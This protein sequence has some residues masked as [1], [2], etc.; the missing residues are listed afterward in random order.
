MNLTVSPP[1]TARGVARAKV[2]DLMEV[3]GVNEALAERIHGHFNG[4]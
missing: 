1:T 2:A 4:G 3:E